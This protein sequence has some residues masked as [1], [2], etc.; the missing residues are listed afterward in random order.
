MIL[1]LPTLLSREQL[2]THTPCFL[3]EFSVLT[4]ELS[5]SVDDKILRNANVICELHQLLTGI[6]LTGHW[7]NPGELPLCKN[8][9]AS[10]PKLR[11]DFR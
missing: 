4:S 2:Y 6:H 3:Y 5:C 9:C 8:V 1:I 11:F 10:I 7:N